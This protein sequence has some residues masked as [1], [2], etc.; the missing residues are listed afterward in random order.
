MHIGLSAVTGDL[1]V[2]VAYA[3]GDSVEPDGTQALKLTLN[4]L[5]LVLNTYQVT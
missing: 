2:A 3:D 1:T 4:M 5:L